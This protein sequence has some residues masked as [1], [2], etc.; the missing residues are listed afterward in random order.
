ML[1]FDLDVFNEG[2][3][4][5]FFGSGAAGLADNS[6]EIAL[7][8]AHLV[9]IET[10]LVLVSSMLVDEIYKAVEYGLFATL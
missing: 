10:D 7:R 8:E 4:N 3:I 1:Q 6:A 9:G 2:A 5:P